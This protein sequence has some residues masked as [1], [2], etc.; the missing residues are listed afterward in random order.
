MD[1]DASSL[2]S[3]SSYSSSSSDDDFLT[4]AGGGLGGTTQQDREALVRKKLLESF[5]GASPGA[6]TAG[7]KDDDGGAN[8]VAGDNYDDGGGE[9]GEADEKQAGEITGRN[10]KDGN[11]DAIKED[12]ATSGNINSSSTSAPQKRLLSPSRIPLPYTATKS[13]LDSPSFDPKSH[14]LSHIAHSSSRVLLE[15]N[16][17]LALD[18]RTLDST[19]QTLV[20]ENY[21]KFID[22]TDAIRSIGTN[23]GSVSGDGDGLDRLVKGMEKIQEASERSERLLRESREAV[24]EKLRIKRLLTRLDALLSLPQTLRSYIREG[25]Y[26]KAVQSHQSA[27]EILG[28]HSAG[29]E[30]LRSIES[31]CGEILKELVVD[32]L[33]EKLID[34]SGGEGIGGGVGASINA[35]YSMDV[36]VSTRGPKSITEIF[37]CAGTLLML[38]PTEFSPGFD[39]S[40]CQSLALAACGQFLRDRLNLAGPSADFE[41]AALACASPERKDNSNKD[42]DMD[43]GIVSELPISFLDG[44]LE[45]TTLYGVSFQVSGDPAAGS[46]SEEEDAKEQELL[47][48]FVRT[49]F[50]KFVNHVRMLLIQRSELDL[51]PHDNDNGH[52]LGEE[53]EESKDDVNFLQISIALSHLLRSVRELASGL[54][55]PEVGLDVSLASTLVDKTVEL[56][57]MLVRRRVATKFK[58]LRGVVVREC[59]APLVREVVQSGPSKKGDKE[60]TDMSGEGGETNDGSQQQSPSLVEVIQLASVALSDGLQMADDLIRATLQRSQLSGATAPGVVAPVDSAVVKLAVQK[61]AKLFG[62]WLASALEQLVGCEP[63]E[64]DDS[65]LLLEVWEDDGDEEN[66]NQKRIIIPPLEKEEVDGDHGRWTS[67]NSTSFSRIDSSFA[68]PIRDETSNLLLKLLVQLNDGVSD[69]IYSN[70]LLAI[71]EMC[72]LAERSMANT[73]NQSIQSAMD[74]DAHRVADSAN[75]LFGDIAINPHRKGKDGLDSKQI[76]SKRFQLAASRALS[77]YVMNRGAHAASELCAEILQL[78]DSRDPYAIPS[79]PREECLRVFDI[80]KESCEDCISIVGGDLFVTPVAPFPDEME[81]VDVFGDRLTGSSGGGGGGASSGLQLDV[82]RMFIEKTQ[83]YPHSLDQLEFTRNSVVSGILRVA[84]SAFL[85]CVRTGVFSSLGYRQLKVDSIFMRYII[86]HYV[87]DEFG[88]TEANACTCLF[89]TIDD[90]MLK[91]GQR[92]FDHEVTNDDDYYDVEKDEIFTPYQLVQ[93]F[94]EESSSLKRI[95][96]AH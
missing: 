6:A 76:L 67:M 17:R 54:A 15:T 16:E 20:Y 80:A 7:D 47:G 43:N 22:A 63:P 94:L 70:F 71:C 21:S 36:A 56:A 25:K 64:D 78:S 59:L 27:T 50:D 69:R 2:H 86:P 10:D 89:N 5:Y 74:E 52:L 46:P 92:C 48:N 73:L 23:V 82:E 75:T 53:Q 24:A 11:D 12:D 58:E 19:M 88:T 55:L 26:R 93:R 60:A 35:S 66:D 8:D 30:S 28:R 68:E 29:F 96:F 77:M 81:Y 38:Y 14:A 61:S 91:A 9:G 83:V 95:V 3:R 42:K 49:N 79:R 4:S 13:D 33:K 51:Q 45:S 31:E 39:K 1:D 37:E 72:R 62:V 90:I 85:E 32:D 41:T 34:W 40:Q 57:E 84:L 18:I 65:K 44:I 87:K